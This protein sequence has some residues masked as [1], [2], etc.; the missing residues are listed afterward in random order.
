MS[1][2]EL[3]GRRRIAAERIER[4]S[5]DYRRANGR[6]V[7]RS[8]ERRAVVVATRARRSVEWLQPES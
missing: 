1:V 8:P 7:S 4:L 2:Y 6:R 3:E 5:D